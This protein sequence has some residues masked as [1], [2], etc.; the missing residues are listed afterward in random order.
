M[1]ATE[2]FADRRA[3]PLSMLAGALDAGAAAFEASAPDVTPAWA[4]AGRTLGRYPPCGAASELLWEA[5][6]DP[7]APAWLVIDGLIALIVEHLAIDAPPSSVVA[8]DRSL[9]GLRRL[10]DALRPFR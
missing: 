10:S 7:L 3:A 1:A 5:T 9:E 8:L 4:A 6:T 2:E